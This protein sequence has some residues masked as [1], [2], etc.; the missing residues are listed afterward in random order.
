MWGT[1][2]GVP[3]VQG[4]GAPQWVKRPGFLPATLDAYIP[5]GNLAALRALN[6]SLE[7]KLGDR[8]IKNLYLVASGPGDG[9]GAN[10]EAAVM[11]RL[12]DKRIFL[13]TR[14][15]RAVVN[16]RRVTATGLFDANDSRPPA[17]RAQ[18]FTE[19]Y[20]PSTLKD[21]VRPYELEDLLTEFL[22]EAGVP[23]ATPPSGFPSGDI[24]GESGFQTEGTAASVCQQLLDSIPGWAFDLDDEGVGYLFQ[25]NDQA[26]TELKFI[27]LTKYGSVFGG[28]TVGLLDRSFLRPKWINV[29]FPARVEMDFY[30]SPVEDRQFAFSL[31]VPGVKTAAPPRFLESYINNPVNDLP[32]LGHRLARGAMLNFHAFLTAFEDLVSSGE[33]KRPD[34]RTASA[35]GPISERLIREFYLRPTNV[36]AYSSNIVGGP[37]PIYLDVFYEIL[38][39]Y[40]LK[41]RLSYEWAPYVLAISTEQVGYVDP[42]SRSK[43]KASVWCDYTGIPGERLVSTRKRTDEENSRFLEHSFSGST[44]STLV[45]NPTAPA[46]A[47]VTDQDT[48][49]F[50]VIFRDGRFGDIEGYGPFI[51]ENQVLNLNISNLKSELSKGSTISEI[52]SLATILTLTPVPSR[53]HNNYHTIRVNPADVAG[54]LP[55]N[56]SISAQPGPT[57]LGACNGPELDI[58]MPDDE[59]F[60]AQFKFYETLSDQC[61]APF[62]DPTATFPESA[63][64]NKDMLEALAKAYAASHYSTL[65]DV[66]T[67]STTIP[68]RDQDFKFSGS[69]NGFSA[70]P[71]LTRVEFGPHEALPDPTMF[72]P[73]S[74]RKKFMRRIEQ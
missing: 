6:G 36:Q 74:L 25:T 27:E 8:T 28:G 26:R 34:G 22:D 70:S 40:R 58:F 53:T 13:T 62:F 50:Q 68:T 7:L 66:Y 72:M 31:P 2:S 69:Y 56:A 63:L 43:A 59:N 42:I 32:F 12:A 64:V 15:V 44:Q 21:G 73:E 5:R 41:Y 60:F 71:D 16:M 65:Q 35:W 24:L 19:E 18:N 37:N 38:R 51:L 57:S 46:Y 9:A 30:Y 14:N 49:A 52:F 47:R 23:F 4:F 1:I 29:R 17:V 48:K 54:L 39:S 33:I 20:Y 3:F 67:G 45:R 55:P 11:I 10:E 61:A